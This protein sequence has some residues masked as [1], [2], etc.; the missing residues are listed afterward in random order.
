MTSAAF[1]TLKLARSLRDRAKFS[2]EQ[3]EGLADA[4]A[5][6][7]QGDLA[8][9]ADVLEQCPVYRTCVRQKI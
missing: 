3:A 7:L 8:T 2:P 4:I 5:E 9:K 1:D 6:A